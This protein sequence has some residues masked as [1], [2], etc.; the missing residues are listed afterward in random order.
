MPTATVR[1]LHV[2]ATEH[3]TGGWIIQQLREAFPFD[4]APRDLIFDNDENYGA[5]VLALI[6]LNERHLHRRQNASRAG[7]GHT[8]EKNGHLE[9]KSRR[10]DRRQSER[11]P[12][13]LSS[14]KP[15]WILASDR[16]SA[17]RR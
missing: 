15:D 1:V 4:S 12:R 14:R 13:N 2:R 11:D 8:V 5:D 9:D 10:R 17:G 16:R 7:Q 3:P 6:V